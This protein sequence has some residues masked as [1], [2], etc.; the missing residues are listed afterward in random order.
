MILWKFAIIS[1]SVFS[2]SLSLLSHR[3]RRSWIDDACMAWFQGKVSFLSL[4]PSFILPLRPSLVFEIF[5]TQRQSLS[6]HNQRTNSLVE[7][8]GDL[9]SQEAVDGYRDHQG[10]EYLRSERGHFE[11]G[12][13]AQEWG[14]SRKENLRSLVMDISSFIVLPKVMGGA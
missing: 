4:Y 1:E 11:E 10:S 13:G 6:F 3:P 14:R 8:H 2:S 5:F 12:P 9:S 7:E